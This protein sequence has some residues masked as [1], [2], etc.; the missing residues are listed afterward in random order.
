MTKKIQTLLIFPTLVVILSCCGKHISLQNSSKDQYRYR[1]F[2]VFDVSKELEPLVSVLSDSLSSR[3]VAEEIQYAAAIFNAVTNDELKWQIS[4]N[5][6]DDVITVLIS[7]EIR[8][9]PNISSGQKDIVFDIMAHNREK[10][11]KKWSASLVIKDYKDTSSAIDKF[12]ELII[13]KYQD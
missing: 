3:L 7:D 12:S 8:E 11:F 4:D 13:T 6:S 2:F 5:M 10:N 1:L 9:N